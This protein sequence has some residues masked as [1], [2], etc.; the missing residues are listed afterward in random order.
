[1]QIDKLT[2]YFKDSYIFLDEKLKP[3]VLEVN[4]TPSFATE[5]QLDAYIKK[6]VIRD[7]L[8]LLNVNVKTKN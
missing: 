8:K 3:Y 6:G 2:E 7:A 4:H 5:S 1:M